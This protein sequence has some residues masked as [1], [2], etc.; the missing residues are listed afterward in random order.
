MTQTVRQAVMA[1]IVNSSACIVQKI[2]DGKVLVVDLARISKDALAE[3]DQIKQDGGVC[4]KNIDGTKAIVSATAC[5][6]EVNLRTGM[7]GE[8][9]TFRE[10]YLHTMDEFWWFWKLLEVKLWVVG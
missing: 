2:E 7:R 5:I 10:I 6:G 8:G 3:L 1:T 9:G 4:L